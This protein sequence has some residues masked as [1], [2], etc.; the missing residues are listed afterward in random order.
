M[1]LWRPDCPLLPSP[2]LKSLLIF[3]SCNCSVVAVRLF[4]SFVLKPNELWRT[5][6]DNVGEGTRV[7]L[8]KGKMLLCFEATAF[9]R[10]FDQVQDALEIPLVFSLELSRSLVVCGLLEVMQSQGGW[11]V[12]LSHKNKLKRLFISICISGNSE[13][14]QISYDKNCLSN[15]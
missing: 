15:T 5:R 3:V 7:N 8:R 10:K 9:A 2:Q 13:L 4:L 14:K 6:G 1:S 11:Y 12:G